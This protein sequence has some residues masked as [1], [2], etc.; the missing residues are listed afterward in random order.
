MQIGGRDRNQVYKAD[1]SDVADTPL[2]LTHAN[3]ADALL[4]RL[5]H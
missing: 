3:M 1:L 2:V 4:A 5:M